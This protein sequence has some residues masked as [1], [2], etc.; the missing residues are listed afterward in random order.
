[1]DIDGDDGIEAFKALRLGTEAIKTARVR[2][3]HGWHFYFRGDL[4]TSAGRLGPH[5]DTR[6]GGKGYAVLPGSVLRNA[7][8]EIE[9]RYE[10]FNSLAIA[11][12]PRT[13]RALLPALPPPD[14]TNPDRDIPLVELDR[15]D[16]IERA[17]LWLT[18]EAPLAIQG[19]G[20][21][22]TTFCAAAKLKDF[23]VSESAAL[24]LMLRHWNARCA[25]P[26]SDDEL[27]VK[28]GN[29]YAY[30]SNPPGSAHPAALF[31][32][33]E[34]PAAEM[35]AAGAESRL[36]LMAGGPRVWPAG[37]VKGLAIPKVGAGFIGGQSRT[38]KTFLALDLAGAL[39]TQRPFFGRQ[40]RE[41]VG[42]LYVAAEGFGTIAKRLEALRLG[43]LGGAEHGEVPIYVIESQDPKELPAVMDAAKAALA[44]GFGLRLGAV[45]IDT[46]AALFNVEDENDAHLATAATQTMAREATRHACLVLGVSHHG[47]KAALGLRGSSAWMASADVLLAATAEINEATGI[48]TNRHL[49]LTKTRDG[50]TGPISGFTLRSVQIGIDDD[51][52]PV[53]AAIVEPCDTGGSAK[54]PAKHAA[55]LIE[56]YDEIRADEAAAPLAKVKERFKDKVKG[57]IDI[58]NSGTVS[59]TWKKALVSSGLVS[60]TIGDQAVLQAGPSVFDGVSMPDAEAMS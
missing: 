49:A 31:A 40:V 12:V 19:R 26:W 18:Q 5:L 32:G 37:L 2:T 30:G 6:G 17:T 35:W 27:A 51:G 16:A 55:A 29:A 1:M 21:D 15:D 8:G 4:P 54:T 14:R 33:V 3:P 7:A 47:K 10:A 11:P 53:E 42:V 59:K 45:F 41:R 20:G 9:G 56:A 36:S 58:T 44:E 28:V 34:P 50:E 52:D 46:I 60:A 13:L 24:S 43:K 25:P 38:G 57:S 22:H 39:A 23:G 48:V